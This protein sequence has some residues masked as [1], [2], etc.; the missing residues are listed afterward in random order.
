[1]VLCVSY[2][3]DSS[4]LPYWQIHSLTP[5]WPE[6][7]PDP[8]AV[9]VVPSLHLAHTRTHGSSRDWTIKQRSKKRRLNLIVVKIEQF[10]GRM[11]YYCC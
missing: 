6:Q 2:I 1:M 4:F 8:V 9:E 10:V 7:A 5:T 3:V 11:Y